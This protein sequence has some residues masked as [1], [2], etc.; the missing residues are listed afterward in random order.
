ML[1]RKIETELMAWK[2]T[3]GHNPLIIKGCRQCG[4]T[5]TVQQFARA[6]YEHVVYVNFFENKDYISIFAGPLDVD[7][8][9]MVMTAML[10]S[11]AVFEEGKTII[12]LDEI[13]ECPQARTALKFFKMD[14]RYDVIGTGSLLG[15]KG[16]REK[17]ASVP[18]GYETVIDMYPLDMEEFLWANGV[19]DEVIKLL[20]L[21]L[22]EE[23]P[24]PEPIH[25]HLNRLL[26]SYIV[27]GGMPAVVE[28]FVQSGDM[29][30]VLRMQR[31]IV[32][33]YEDDMVKYDPEEDKSLIRQ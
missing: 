28:R 12:I 18:V 14:G 22:K 16:Y 20:E 5:Y 13:Q 27:V 3:E 2:N 30:A 31:D 7:Y 10:G 25:T 17:P 4:K 9:T 1:K 11:A 15:V 32:A 24:V 29:N 33:S 6:N 23:K 26:L 19:T 21:C 8:L